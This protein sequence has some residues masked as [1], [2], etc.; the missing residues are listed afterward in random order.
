MPTDI[1][2]STLRLTL[3]AANDFV[4]ELVRI[5]RG[6]RDFTDALILAAVFQANVA[7]MRGDLRL[8]QKYA[9]FYAPPPENVRRP[10]SVSAVAASLSLP[11]ETVR[12]R[13]ARLTAEGLLDV[14]R[15]GVIF[16]MRALRSSAHRIALEQNFETVR[17][18][19]LR[20]KR[21]GVMDAMGLPPARTDIADPAAPPLRI[22]A[23]LSADYVLR[24]VE[25]LT[26]GGGD[27]T[28]GFI[29]MA[30]VRANTRDVPDRM[31]GADPEGAGLLDDALRRPARP[32]D[33]ARE[34]G[35]SQETTRRRL[36]QLVASG[37]CMARDGGV[38]VPQSVLARPPI[39]EAMR[40]NYVN[41]AR[42]FAGLAELGV[43]AVWDRQAGAMEAAA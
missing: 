42:M 18:L 10:V 9:T 28:N 23:R 38:V 4:L 6:R 12:R 41:L 37:R 11:F 13:V 3:R 27:A 31:R 16:S 40:L 30:V 22:A 14:S 5:G 15:R 8:Q 1:P 25:L 20:L 33:I 39:A 24:M 17:A 32:A 21:A 35:L 19:Y 29:L 26:A 34:L 43:L 36:A 7:P 2:P